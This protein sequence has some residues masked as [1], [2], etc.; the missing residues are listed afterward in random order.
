M[1]RLV[2]VSDFHCGHEV[3][4]TPPTWNTQ[5]NNRMYGYRANQWN[6][7][8]EILESLKPIDVLVAN[9]DL[10]DGRGERTG[11][12]ELIEPDRTE[13]VSMAVKSILVAE[14]KKIFITRGTDYHV[15]KAESWENLIA[16]EVGAKRIGDVINVDVEGTV[17]NFRHHLGTSQTPVGRA[18]GLLKEGIWNQLWELR[19]RP[20]AD[21]MVR[22][23][24]H[25]HTY[26]GD[27]RMLVLT[28][29]ALQGFGSRF[30]ERRMSGIIDW[31]V[32]YFDVHGEKDY[33]WRAIVKPYEFPATVVA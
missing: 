9:G 21:V 25:Y 17:F 7:Y 30:G 14:A 12:V 29:P 2:V 32:V 18:T 19:G 6:A 24:V 22:S 10:I 1:K 26:V 11:G 31:G 28:T 13:Q 23:H 4:L 15:G 27:P 20:G 3:G 8:S 5:H 16:K 33:Q